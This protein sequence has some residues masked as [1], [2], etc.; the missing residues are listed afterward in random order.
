MKSVIACGLVLVLLAGCK[1]N[2]DKASFEKAVSELTS[3]REAAVS[4]GLAIDDSTYRPPQFA[5]G[6][7]AAPHYRK[8]SAIWQGH[9][10]S[11]RNAQAGEWSAVV[12]G[13]ATPSFDG[14]EAMLEHV[15][16]GAARKGCNFERDLS[17]GFDIAYDELADMKSFAKA[18]AAR[19]FASA[20]QGRLDLA[21]RDLVAIQNMARHAA[22]EEVLIGQLVAI[23][24]SKIGLKALER[25]IGELGPRPAILQMADEV[26][27]QV[28]KLAFGNGIRGEIALGTVAIRKIRS[29]DKIKELAGA[30]APNVSETETA[31]QLSARIDKAIEGLEQTTINAAF[32]ARHLQYWTQAV[33][34]GKELDNE[35]FGEF[36][37]KLSAETPTGDATYSLNRILTPVFGMA[38]KAMR[39]LDETCNAFKAGVKILRSRGPNKMSQTDMKSLLDADELE[40]ER[41]D[42]GFLIASH[43]FLPM[44]VNGKPAAKA[45]YGFTYPYRGRQ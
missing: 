20:R 34:E 4:A 37:D 33:R 44:V 1:S 17:E 24:L 22:F 5:E 40:L 29:A 15:V 30:N 38:G 35:K 2:A 27:S 11:K 36:L 10:E 16:T 39:G 31:A 13:K 9:P 28:P 23:A 42:T 6:D 21:K 41:T 32:E 18:L 8:A 19:S 43:T 12:S 14:Y 7:N 3:A 45:T 25:T 26:L